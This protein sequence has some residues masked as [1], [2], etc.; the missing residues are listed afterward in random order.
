M[1]IEL[2][3]RLHFFSVFDLGSV[4]LLRGIE[5]GQ[6]S[7]LDVLPENDALQNKCQVEVSVT[8][9]HY[10]SERDSHLEVMAGSLHSVASETRCRHREDFVQLF[11]GY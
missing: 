10:E 6:G 9:W 4:L 5:V 7:A 8:P 1:Y 2:L 11:E 3:D